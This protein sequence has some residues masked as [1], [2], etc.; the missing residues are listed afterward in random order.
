MMPPTPV[1][2]VGQQTQGRGRPGGVVSPEGRSDFLSLGSLVPN[3][4]FLQRKGPHKPGPALVGAF[5][6]PYR[7]C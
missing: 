5:G 7:D 1:T 2:A 6:A 4:P 3:A